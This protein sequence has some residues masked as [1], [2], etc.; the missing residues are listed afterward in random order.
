MMFYYVL[1]LQSILGFLL[2]ERTSGVSPV[3]FIKKSPSKEEEEEE[4]EEGMGAKFKAL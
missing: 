4:E 3:I 2:S 1:C